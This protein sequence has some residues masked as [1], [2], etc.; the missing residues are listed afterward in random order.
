MRGVPVQARRLRWLVASGC[1]AVLAVVGLGTMGAGGWVAA[2]QA[3]VP[4]CLGTFYPTGAEQPC[5]VPAGLAAIHVLVVGGSGYSSPPWGEGAFLA[6]DVSVT[7]GETLYVEVGKDASTF[8]GYGGWNGGGKGTPSRGAASTRSRQPRPAAS[9]RRT[10][11]DRPRRADR[12]D[13]GEPGRS[14]R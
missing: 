7:P 6:T 12:R 3:A 1:G 4:S 14:A 8:Q 2:S 10:A 11:E 9:A 13:A 5:S